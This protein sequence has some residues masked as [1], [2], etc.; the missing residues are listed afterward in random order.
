MYRFDLIFSYWVFVWWLLYLAKW[1]KT[2]PQFAILLGIVENLAVV[3]VFLLYA[4]KTATAWKTLK[5]FLTQF[6]FKFIPLFSLLGEPI[7]WKQELVATGGL[8]LVYSTWLLCNRENPGTVYTHV[9]KVVLG[10]EPVSPETTPFIAWLS[11][12]V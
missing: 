10:R 2:S 11:K 12:W 4:P 3:I 7:V 8:F 9:Y 6:S 5:L 1:V